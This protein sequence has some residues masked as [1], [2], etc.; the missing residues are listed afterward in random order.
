MG[1]VALLAAVLTAL[2]GCAS[3]PP[4]PAAST[5]AT[6]SPASSPPSSISSSDPIGPHGPS[7]PTEPAALAAVLEEARRTVADPTRS[8]QDVAAAGRTAQVAYEELAFHPERL[9]PV[10]AALSPETAEATG[11]IVGAGRDLL[12]MAKRGPGEMLPAWRIAAPLPP[13][14]LRAHY[15]EA[16]ERFGVPWTVLAAVNLVESRMGRIA[17]H[18]EAGARGPMQFMPATWASYGLGGDVTDPHDAILGAANYLRANGGATADGLDRALER[19]NDD[20]RYVRAVRAYAAV[21]QDD[22]RAYLAFHAWEVYFRTTAGRVHL[23][24]GY[25][26]AEPVRA[27]D[28]LAR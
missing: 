11:R 16:Q 15:A 1:V 25:D 19:Y 4:S 21:M 23:P 28:Y 12:A 22:E 27:V 5:P 13:E 26:E 6:P 9:P 17:S 14:R 18:S 2:G 10:L 8:P 24:V 7:V 20:E 3:G